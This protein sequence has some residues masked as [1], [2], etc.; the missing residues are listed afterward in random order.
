MIKKYLSNKQIFNG[1]VWLNYPNN[2]NNYNNTHGNYIGNK[3]Y[4]STNMKKMVNKYEQK[5]WT[6]MGQHLP[7]KR[8]AK[9]V[10]TYIDCISSAFSF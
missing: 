1:S 2:N 4:W 9:R 10:Y 8:F 6:N 7:N 3:T 5:W